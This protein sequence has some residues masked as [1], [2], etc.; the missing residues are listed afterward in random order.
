[1]KRTEILVDQAGNMKLDQQGFS[2]PACEEAT[3]KIMAGIK[4]DKSTTEKKSEFYNRA[5]VADKAQQRW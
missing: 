5:G 2:G 1:M 3:K 4:A